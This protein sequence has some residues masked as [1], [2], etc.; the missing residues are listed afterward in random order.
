MVYKEFY[1]S[2]YGLWYIKSFIIP[3]IVYNTLYGI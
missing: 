3:Y 1:N 2:L